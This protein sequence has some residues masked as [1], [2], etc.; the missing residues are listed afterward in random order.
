M[1]ETY[2]TKKESQD[3]FDKALLF[4]S[5]GK[6]EEAVIC[7][8]KSLKANPKNAQTLYNLGVAYATLGLIDQ[9]ISCW[10]RSIWLEPDFRYE[11]IKA[12]AIDDE[13]SESV[14]GD[15]FIA[16]DDCYKVA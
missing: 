14:I 6:T 3:L 7:Y 10:R 5:E 9:A 4:E 8:Q 11:L 15:D 13:L 1:T 16:Y 2:W 12:F